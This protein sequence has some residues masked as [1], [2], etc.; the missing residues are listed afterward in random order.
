[1]CKD[2]SVETLRLAKDCSSSIAGIDDSSIGSNSENSDLISVRFDFDKIILQSRIYQ[3]VQRS[4]LRQS[5]RVSKI[6]SSKPPPIP[7]LP[8]DMALEKVPLVVQGPQLVDTETRISRNINTS[9]TNPDALRH[10]DPPQSAWQRGKSR[11]SGWWKKPPM[12]WSIAAD[13]DSFVKATAKSSIQKVVILGASESGKS[14]VLKAINFHL[15]APASYFLCG[16]REIIWS[17]VVHS[18]RSVLEAM[19]SLQIPLQ[20][21]R[22]ECYSQLIFHQPSTF[23]SAPKSNVARAIELL[24]NDVGFQ[25]T[26][27]Q[28]SQYHLLD[29]AGYFAR[30]VA[31]LVS[32]EYQPTKQD[33]IYASLPTKGVSGVNLNFRNVDYKIFDVGGALSERKHWVHTLDNAAAFIFTIDA[34]SYA[35][36]LLSKEKTSG[37]MQEQLILFATI[38][39][40]S[41][42]SRSSFVIVFTKCDHLEQWFRTNPVEDYFPDFNPIMGST[43]EQY[44]RY[45]ELKFL[46]LVP[47]DGRG[48]RCRFLRARFDDI[49]SHNPA[50][51]ILEALHELVAVYHNRL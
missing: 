6:E 15:A 7:S 4:R 23:D 46:D 47:W 31:R 3:E 49:D 19:K 11:L 16:F 14:T 41:W 34:S 42:S 27:Q 1:M 10:S 2:E 13:D 37:R 29:V 21:P 35:K 43:V 48:E 26:Y 32:T 39:N 33:V 18:T 20:D 28:R 40:S 8:T 50:E 17:N 25:R 44:I 24:W 30:D 51:E 9:R 5:I 12:R 45:L 38:I 22:L 36:L